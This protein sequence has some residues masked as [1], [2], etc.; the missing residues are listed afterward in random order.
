MFISR[1][2]LLSCVNRHVSVSSSKTR[3]FCSRDFARMMSMADQ[4]EALSKL[5]QPPEA[6][7]CPC[8]PE[9]QLRQAQHLPRLRMSCSCRIPTVENLS[10][11][12]KPAIAAT[13]AVMPVIRLIKPLLHNRVGEVQPQSKLNTAGQTMKF[14]SQAIKS[15]DPQVAKMSTVFH[16]NMACCLDDHDRRLT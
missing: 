2:T 8:S 3:S 15:G 14:L 11:T 12:H 9:T 6:K 10:P 5:L 13:L 1:L 7:V 4:Y 16:Y